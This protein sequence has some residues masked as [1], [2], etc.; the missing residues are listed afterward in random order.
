MP[1]QISP[2]MLADAVHGTRI[3]SLALEADIVVKFVMI[4]LV[5]ARSGSGPWCST[6][7]GASSRSRATAA[8]EQAFWSRITPL[9]DL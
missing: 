2:S 9:A 1:D 5:L 4:L 8:F 6:R 3:L 7:S